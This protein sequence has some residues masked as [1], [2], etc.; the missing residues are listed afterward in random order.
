M[1]KNETLTLWLS[2][3]AAIFA[4]M[5][6]YSY[7]QEKSDQ[8][9]KK[10]GAMTSVVT[11]VR[12][13]GEME[14]VDDSMVQL[15]EYPS[16]FVQPEA[17]L[18]MEEA[19][20]L[21]ALAPLSKGEQVLRTKITR[22][23]PTTGL[24]LQ[25]SPTKR[26]LTIP[27]DETRGVAKLLKPGDRVDVVVALDVRDGARQKKEIKTL[28]QDV[29]ILATGIK[30]VNELPRVFEEVSGS[31][32][33]RNIRAATDFNSITVEAD[34]KD[35]QDLVYVLATAPGSLFLSLRHPSDHSINQHLPVSS[36]N[37]LLGRSARKPASK[38][39]N[40]W[41]PKLKRRK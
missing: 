14:T 4:V 2:I 1:N 20:G 18:T 30:V 16:S 6:L 9:A 35:I 13:I 5:L 19:I 40:S 21:V 29:V 41:I 31:S 7:T 33:I 25:V 23:G 28:M 39:N 3:G 11:A 37:S 36:L 10:F 15:K 17:I 32:F 22:P 24:S 12:D 26:A 27:I 38:S 8:I 34:P